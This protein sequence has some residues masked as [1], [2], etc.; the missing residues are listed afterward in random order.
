MVHTYCDGKYIYSV[1]MM[2]VYIRKHKPKEV[3]I[4]VNDFKSQL[5][6]TM[7]GDPQKNI[8]YAPISVIVDPSSNL[9]EYE[10]ILNAN[11]SYPLIITTEGIVVDGMHRLSRMYIEKKHSALAY[12]FDSHL[13]KK[14][15]IAKNGE[16]DKVNKM[17]IHDFINLYVDKF[18]KEYSK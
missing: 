7:W 3:S 10:R 9:P 15:V 12:M 17:Q 11:L 6:N 8:K 18:C 16:W 4:S 13:M 14:F 2:F 1:D 5:S